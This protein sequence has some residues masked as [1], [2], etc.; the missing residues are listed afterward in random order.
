MDSPMPEG[1]EIAN[2][3]FI[4]TR[5]LERND[6]G[7]YRCEAMNDVGLRSEDVHFWIQGTFEKQIYF[8]LFLSLSLSLFYFILFYNVSWTK[9]P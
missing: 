8:S 3:S 9:S 2:K 6:S 1:V 7:V 5:P 4:F